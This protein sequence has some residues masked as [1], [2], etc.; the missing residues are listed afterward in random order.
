LAR[1]ITR[2][3]ASAPHVEENSTT[4][5]VVSDLASYV[6]VDVGGEMSDVAEPAY[7][8]V[9][10]AAAEEPAAVVCDLSRVQGRRDVSAVARLAFLGSEVQDWPGTPIGVV[11]PDLGLRNGLAGQHDGRYLVLGEDRGQVLAQLATLTPPTIIRVPLPATARSARAARDLVARACLDWGCSAQIGAATLIVSEL[12]TNTVLHA[13]TDL[14]VSLAR[15]GS[16]LRVAVHD[17]NDLLPTPRVPDPTHISGRG[18]LLVA[19]VSQSWGAVRT[20][21]G[22]K[23]VWAV[24]DTASEGQTSRTPS[25]TSPHPRGQRTHH[26]GSGA[27]LDAAC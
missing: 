21:T 23:V 20:T 2:P 18:M 19:A 3:V 26:A 4:P 7:Q 8:A 5:V 25:G 13:G 9:L 22:G 24:L 27:G 11:C 16:R 15:S 12:V 1:R 14:W 6:L 17:N 10:S